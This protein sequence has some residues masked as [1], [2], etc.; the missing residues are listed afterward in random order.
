M[1]KIMWTLVGDEDGEVKFIPYLGDGVE[2]DGD[3]TLTAHARDLPAL[4]ASHNP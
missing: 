2:C 3:V 4:T 1:V